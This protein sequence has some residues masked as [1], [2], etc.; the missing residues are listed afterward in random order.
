MFG[1]LSTDCCDNPHFL[2]VNLTYAVQGEFKGR[3][4]NAAFWRFQGQQSRAG[5]QLSRAREKP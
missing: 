3:S 5:F 1:D 2:S 4:L